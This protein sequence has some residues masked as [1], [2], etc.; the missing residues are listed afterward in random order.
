MSLKDASKRLMRAAL[1]TGF[2]GHAFGPTASALSE[3]PERSYICRP[4]LPIFCRNVHV[5]CSGKTDIPTSPF[6]IT[7]SGTE[8]QIAYND[9]NGPVPGDVTKGPDLVIRLSG[10][11]DWIHIEPNGRY[12]HRIYRNG[13]A[14]MSYGRCLVPEMPHAGKDHG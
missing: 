9:R 8:A 2:L 13:L 11:N 14:A 4:A 12:S 7:L 6:R 10:T 5:S 3:K 1:L